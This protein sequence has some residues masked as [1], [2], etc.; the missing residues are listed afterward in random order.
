MFVV[1]LQ[2][3]SPIIAES[4]E[5]A[6][7]RFVEELEELN[8]DVS[9]YDVY[10]TEGG[11]SVIAH[12]VNDGPPAFERV[13]HFTKREVEDLIE[14]MMFKA[15]CDDS[16]LRQLCQMAALQINTDDAYSDWTDGKERSCTPT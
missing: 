7:R 8:K 11:F 15:Q 12:N 4:P 3:G 1:E 9:Y 10:H 2:Q 14:E 13:V 6:V 5:A 16:V